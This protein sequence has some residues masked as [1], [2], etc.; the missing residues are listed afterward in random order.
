MVFP[1]LSLLG[2]SMKVEDK[3]TEVMVV[4]VCVCVRERPDSQQAEMGKACQAR[5]LGD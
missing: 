4:C 1:R 5:E 2:T 3:G